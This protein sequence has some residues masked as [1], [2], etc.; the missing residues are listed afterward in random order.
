MRIIEYFATD[1]QAYWLSQIGK[2]DWVAGQFLYELLK[3]EKLQQY[4]GDKT[5]V[6]MLVDGEALI[7]F[8]TL[9]NKDDIEQTDLRPWIGFVYTFP[10]YRGHRYIGKLLNYAKEMARAKGLSNIYVSTDQ[11]GI[12]EK[13]GFAFLA[14]MKDRRDGDSRVYVCDLLTY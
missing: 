12:Y 4:S 2:S 6:F 7:S 5:K 9:S 14:Y 1:N 3:N 11:E 10:Q 13:Y 8:C